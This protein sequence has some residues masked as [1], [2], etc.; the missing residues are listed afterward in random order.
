MKTITE[1]KAGKRDR[2]HARIRAKLAGTADRPR[3]SVYRSNKAIYLQIIDDSAG[4]T[5]A[6]F[7]TASVKKG[8]LTEKAREAG[9]E[10]AKKA[11]EKGVTK[12]VFDRG[13]FLFA[14]RIK[15]AADGAREGGLKF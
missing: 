14:G 6:S 9:K 4:S 5:L 1:I 7:S 3:L 15:A 10:I 11:A 12:V 13:G 8:T 2:R